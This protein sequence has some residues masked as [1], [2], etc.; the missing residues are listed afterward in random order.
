MKS[1][2]LLKAFLVIATVETL[3]L[4]ISAGAARTE[5][6]SSEQNFGS[7]IASLPIEL[8]QKQ[9]SET[10]QRFRNFMAFNRNWLEQEGSQDS[11]GRA[12]WA[13]GR[14]AELT[15]NHGLKL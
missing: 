10:E 2:Q 14:T 13:I 1:K 6:L 8:S 12:V 9:P 15:R 4:F 11:F 3:S 7:Y 5:T